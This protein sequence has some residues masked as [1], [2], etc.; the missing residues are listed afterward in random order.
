MFDNF[1]MILSLTITMFFLPYLP[2]RMKSTHIILK[3][4]Q[5]NI[6]IKFILNRRLNGRTIPIRLHFLIRTEDVF[7]TL[8]P[9][10]KRREITYDQL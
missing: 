2:C 4:F 3:D 6:H 8:K 9:S 10:K 7:M 1:I 5:I